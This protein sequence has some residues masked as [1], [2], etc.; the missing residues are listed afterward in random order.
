MLLRV[1]LFLYLSGFAAV[2]MAQVKGIEPAE[3]PFSGNIKGKTWALVVGVSNYE[4]KKIPNL[5]YAAED[6]LAFAAYLQSPAGGLLDSSHLRLLLN[7]QAK[8]ADFGAGLSWLQ[9]VS[10][11]GDRVIIFFSGHADVES[12]WVDQPGYLLTY[13]SPYHGYDQGGAYSIIFL[14]MAVNT[15]TTKNKASVLLISDACHSGKLGGSAISGAQLA[16]RDL[17]NRIE[18]DI[19]VLSCQENE[20]S[21]EG[22][23]WGGG[24]ACLP[25]FWSRDCMAWQM[26]TTTA[27]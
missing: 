9:E 27:V 22:Y 10:R 26:P 5:N 1:V 3:E 4:N 2:L 17:S 21:L 19:K 24:T 6:A 25:I 23:Q 7:E 13:N 20:Y 18:S 12:S 8:Q 11:E 15:L 14:Q 16:Y